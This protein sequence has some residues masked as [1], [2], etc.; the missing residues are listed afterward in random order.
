MQFE[1]SFA[2]LAA[3]PQRDRPT[4]GDAA[5]NDVDVL[6]EREK[7]ARDYPVVDDPVGEKHCASVRGDDR[8][9]HAPLS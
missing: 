7:G 4:G 5:I 1:V 2:R 8:G 3:E 6:Y 9:P